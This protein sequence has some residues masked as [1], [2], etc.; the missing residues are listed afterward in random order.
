MT[1]EKNDSIQDGRPTWSESFPDLTQDQDVD[2]DQKF[3]MITTD[4]DKILTY[5]RSIGR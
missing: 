1:H 3:N 4:G 2:Y 5:N